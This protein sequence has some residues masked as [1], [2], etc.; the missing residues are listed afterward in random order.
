M[1]KGGQG[2]GIAHRSVCKDPGVDAG[3][4]GS[5]KLKGRVKD[6][7]GEAVGAGH[8]G[9]CRFLSWVFYPFIP[10][11]LV[12]LQVHI[13]VVSG[14]YTLQ[15][16]LQLVFWKSHCCAFVSVSGQY[17]RIAESQRVR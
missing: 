2:K 10:G 5:G 8:A 17:T 13:Q 12:I 1:K 6:D 3:S 15:T 4:R 7:T 14:F 16:I 11:Y 9:P